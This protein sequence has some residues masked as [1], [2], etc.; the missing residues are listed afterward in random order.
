MGVYTIGETL[1]EREK[2]G[3]PAVRL[4]AGFFVLYQIDVVRE[5]FQR[6]KKNET[7]SGILFD[8]LLG[9]A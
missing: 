2:S 6:I 7:E 4:I 1:P 9:L 8:S 5:V 3:R